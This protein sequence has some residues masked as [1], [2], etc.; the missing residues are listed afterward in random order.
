MTETV[1]LSVIIPTLG[2]MGLLP[3]CL[4]SLAACNPRAAEVIVVVQG[5]Q[6]GVAELIARFTE[7]GARSLACDGRGRGLGLNVGLREAKHDLVLVT[8]DD[9]RVSPSWVGVA[10]AALAGDPDTILTGRVLADGDPDTVPATIDDPVARDYFG[11]QGWGMLYGGNMACHREAVLALG[12]FDERMQPSAEDDEL[13]YR[14]VRAGKRIRYD[15]ELVVWH[16]AWRTPEQLADAYVGYARG[17]GKFYGKHLRR[18]DL[19]LV[20]SVA[21]QL[22]AGMRGLAA[23][24]IRRRPRWSDPRRGI[25]RGL[26]P[27]LVAGWREAKPGARRGAGNRVELSEARGAS[28]A[29]RASDRAAA[30]H[31]ASGAGHAGSR[32]G[33]AQ[34]KPASSRQ[35]ICRP[36]SVELRRQPPGAGVLPPPDG[37]A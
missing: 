11:P 8:D 34:A 16:T 31:L 22:Y 23:G 29:R 28:A 1:P 26:P 2:R 5:R 21:A 35:R 24:L 19:R 7:S 17:Q 33:R 36:G 9:C 25:L 20:G 30:K 18:G 6:D 13:S 3:A 27:G 12:G 37:G 32:R 15:P 10:S 14:W 4:K